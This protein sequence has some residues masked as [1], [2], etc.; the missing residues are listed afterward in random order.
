MAS[1]DA[2]Y[3]QRRYAT[4]PAESQASEFNFVGRT[5]SSQGR[6]LWMVKRRLRLTPEPEVRVSS[7]I[8]IQWPTCRL[9]AGLC[10]TFFCL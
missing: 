2:E 8:Q 10:E 4:K 9:V 1:R 7:H 5:S 3:S 6:G